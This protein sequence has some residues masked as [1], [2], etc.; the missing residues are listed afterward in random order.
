MKGYYMEIRILIE[1]ENGRVTSIMSEDSNAFFFVIH[2][3][4]DKREVRMFDWPD[5][6][7]DDEYFKKNSE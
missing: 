3:E 5:T 7:F 2:K 4:G 6:Q 1:V